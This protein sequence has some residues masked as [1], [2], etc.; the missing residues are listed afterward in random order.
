MNGLLRSLSTT[1][2]VYACRYMSSKEM[3]LNKSVNIKIDKHTI[4]FVCDEKVVVLK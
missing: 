2:R 1:V 3:F 4:I